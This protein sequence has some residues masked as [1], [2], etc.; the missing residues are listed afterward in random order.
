[1]PKRTPKPA[2]GDPRTVEVIAPDGK[3]SDWV[4]P[5]VARVLENQG[6]TRTDGGGTADAVA[7]AVEAASAP[8]NQRIAE[9]EAQLAS[10]PDVAAAVAPLLERITELETDLEAAK[11]ASTDTPDAG[12]TGSKEP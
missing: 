4:T 3:G 11:A 6:W 9:L 7:K 8:L 1:M 10:D 2:A 5:E 12:D